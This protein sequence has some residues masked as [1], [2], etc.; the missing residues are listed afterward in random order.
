M[1]VSL[2]SKLERHFLQS[3]NEIRSKTVMMPVKLFK[4]NQSDLKSLVNEC[5]KTRKPREVE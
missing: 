2:K 1:V 3:I 5:V 4:D